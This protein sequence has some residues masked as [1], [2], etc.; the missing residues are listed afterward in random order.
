MPPTLIELLGNF[1]IGVIIEQLIDEGNELRSRTALRTE[2]KRHGLGRSPF[3]AHMSGHH[4]ILKQ[5]HIFQQ[6]T[7]HAFAIPIRGAWIF[8]HAGKILDEFFNGLFFEGGELA[9]F[10][11][12]LPLDFFLD[13]G[14][15]A[16]A[17]VPVGFQHI[18]YQ[19]VLRIHPRDPRRCA[20]SAA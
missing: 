15:F 12:M 3:E 19:T 9:L 16:Q 11:L 7:H 4:L 1:R 14:K 5:G 18:S 8:P 20:N 2:R 17:S 13:L 6:Q 10:C